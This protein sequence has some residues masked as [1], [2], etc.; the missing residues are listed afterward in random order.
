MEQ[1]LKELRVGT[2]FTLAGVSY[3]V[4]EKGSD[5][6]K[7]FCR[8][9]NNNEKYFRSD[10]TI[11]K[12]NPHKHTVKK[13][14]HHEIINQKL[15]RS[16]KYQERMAIKKQK[17]LDRLPRFLVK[18]PDAMHKEYIA[19]G[20]YNGHLKFHCQ[21]GCLDCKY[22]G[23]KGNT[24]DIVDIHF[25]LQRYHVLNAAQYAKIRGCSRQYVSLLTRQGRLPY[26]RVPNRKTKYIIWHVKLEEIFVPETFIHEQE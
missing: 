9:A 15:L 2:K 20:I 7:T 10:T 3:T 19:Y 26:F 14:K 13:Y 22:M 21:H 4:I 17:R 6:Y 11:W 18:V 24:R 1:Q 5:I 12:P 23:W 8:D 16:A 25:D